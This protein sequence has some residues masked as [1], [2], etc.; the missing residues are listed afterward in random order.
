MVEES[1][2]EER[3]EKRRKERERERQERKKER[4]FLDN[5]LNMNVK[6]NKDVFMTVFQTCLIL[7]PY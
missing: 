6:R 1:E 5:S 2:K 4:I 3:E 7:Y